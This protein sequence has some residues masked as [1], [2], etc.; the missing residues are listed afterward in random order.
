[1]RMPAI[2]A[3]LMSFDHRSALPLNDLAVDDHS[4]DGDTHHTKNDLRVVRNEVVDH[5]FL[6]RAIDDVMISHSFPCLL[7]L[8]YQ[9]AVQVARVQST[10]FQLHSVGE[11]ARLS[12]IVIGSENCFC[13]KRQCTNRCL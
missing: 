4:D 11:L 7:N 12:D 1:M 10:N 13:Q 5:L 2:D 9:V 8:F 3:T 6:M